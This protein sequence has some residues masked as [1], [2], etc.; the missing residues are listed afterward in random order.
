MSVHLSADFQSIV[1][2]T[3]LLGGIG[4]RLLARLLDE[5]GRRRR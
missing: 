2:T 1:A 3:L 4:E 5:I